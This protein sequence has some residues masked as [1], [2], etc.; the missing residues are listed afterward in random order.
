MAKWG[1]GDPRWIVEERPDATNVNNWHWTERDA[2]SWS[3]DKLK[4]LFIGAE[5]KSN[6]ASIKVYEIEKCEGEAS[7]NNRK[8]KLIFFYEWAL[9]LKWKGT[10]DNNDEVYEGSVTIPNLSEENEVDEIDIQVSI[11][12]NLI[13]AEPLKEIMNKEG[14]PI[15]RDLLNG[16]VKNLHLEFSKGMILPPKEGGTGDKIKNLSSG[17]NKKVSMQPVVSNSESKSKISDLTTISVTEK[18][19]CRARDLYDALTRIEMVTAFTRGQVKLELVPG[20]SF[21]LFGGNIS[22]NFVELIP[23]EKIVQKW[24]CKQWPSEHFSTVTIKLDQKSDHTVL[25]VV[26]TDVPRSEADATKQ[27]WE[28]YYWNSIKQ[29]FGFGALLH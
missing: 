21:E 2:S 1:E 20:G 26:Q 8:G 18:F 27:N 16:Y 6:G 29:T 15:I 23:N 17:F 3:K 13:E 28:R 12:D 25:H 4:Q 5:V 10:I 24:R 11:K 7:A 9:V 14:K 22:G 19:Q